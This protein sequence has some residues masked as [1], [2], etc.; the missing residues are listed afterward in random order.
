MTDNPT[1]PSAEP[2]PFRLARRCGAK[3]RTGQPCRS[4][5]V[6][7]RP[8]CRMHGCGRGSGGPR[9][10][11]NGNF[12]H[13]LRTKEAEAERQQAKALVREAMRLLNRM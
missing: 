12:R 2:L 13:G 11:L 1:H 7:G 10:E 8:R 5:A 9:G 3:T 4:P 6:R